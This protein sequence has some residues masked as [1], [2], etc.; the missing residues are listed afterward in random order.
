MADDVNEATEALSAALS[1]A[2]A[3]LVRTEAEL[4][5]SKKRLTSLTSSLGEM[6]KTVTPFVLETQKHPGAIGSDK[7]GGSITYENL[8]ALNWLDQKLLALID[9]LGQSQT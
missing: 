8:N 4:D 7:F 9:E 6:R 3:A 5:A 2:Q 1:Q